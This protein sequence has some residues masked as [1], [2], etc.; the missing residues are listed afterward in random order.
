MGAE[1]DSEVLTDQI[2][3]VDERSEDLQ[4]PFVRSLYSHCGD[5]PALEES[6]LPRSVPH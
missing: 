3:G 6:R 2:G 5:L 1:G 4:V